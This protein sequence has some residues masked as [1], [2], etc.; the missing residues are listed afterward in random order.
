MP[1]D[2][3]SIEEA[4]GERHCVARHVRT[5]ICRARC[6]T[7]RSVL[8]ALDRAPVSGTGRSGGGNPP[9]GLPPGRRWQDG[10]RVL[11]RPGTLA[12]ILCGHVRRASR[13]R[14]RSRT[15]RDATLRGAGHLLTLAGQG[16]R[17]LARAALGGHGRGD[18]RNQRCELDRT[19]LRH[20][21]PARTAHGL[22]YIVRNE[23]VCLLA[24]CL[25]L[26][27]RSSSRAPLLGWPGC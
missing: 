18:A 7:V 11:R 22:V 5:R 3:L 21:Q 17:T 10:A 6:A 26:K 24:L 9:R 2:V 12:R 16:R 1:Q 23:A 13:N 20:Q 27:F 14:E 19:S 25:P 4:F 8:H 15:H